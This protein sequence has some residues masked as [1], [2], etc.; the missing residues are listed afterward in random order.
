MR[1]DGPGFRLDLMVGADDSPTAARPTEPPELLVNSL[2]GGSPLADKMCH[3]LTESSSDCPAWCSL[4][5]EDFYLISLQAAIFLQHLNKL[6]LVVH[7]IQTQT[8]HFWDQVVS[9]NQERH[10]P[11][12]CVK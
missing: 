8:G 5:E 12:V 9:I 10:A 6:V 2:V 1:L 4:I 7:R 3:D 11:I